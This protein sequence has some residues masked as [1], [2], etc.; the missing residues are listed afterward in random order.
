MLSGQDDT[1]VLPLYKR[2]KFMDYK[3][4]INPS[5]EKKNYQS[6]F[7]T[8]YLFS[9]SFSKKNTYLSYKDS[10]NLTKKAFFPPKVSA[11]LAC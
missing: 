6:F 4:P 7:L 1:L 3:N 8:A 11:T 9:K 2:T 5:K 10:L